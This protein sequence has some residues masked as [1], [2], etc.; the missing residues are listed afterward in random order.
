MTF[1]AWLWLFIFF[2]GAALLFCTIYLIISF[3]D[4]ECDHINPIDMCKRLNPLVL[5]EVGGQA[6]LTVMLLL[7]GNW[8]GFI[9]NAPITAWNVMKV[10][11]KNHM[12]DSTTLI[13]KLEGHKKEAYVKLGLYLLY[14]FYYMYRMVYALVEGMFD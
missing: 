7:T 11:N 13:T 1:D 2:L 6:G 12:Y 5:P 14:F 3:S 10:Q 8:F 9:L 4:L